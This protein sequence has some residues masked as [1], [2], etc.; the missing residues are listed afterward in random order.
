MQLVLGDKYEHVREIS[1]R[2]KSGVQW[3]RY[4]SKDSGRSLNARE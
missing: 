3:L 2:I 4:W 1:Q